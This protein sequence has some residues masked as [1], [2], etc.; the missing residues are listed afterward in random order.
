[1]RQR[2]QKKISEIVADKSASR[3]K[4]VLKQPAQQRFVARERDHAVAYIA[5]RQNPVFAAQPAGAAAVIRD[6][7][8]RGEIGDRPFRSGR[9]IVAWNHVMFQSAQQRRKSRPAAQG[10]DAQAAML[11]VFFRA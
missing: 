1:M 3:V 6:G 4:P 8:D 2:R 9:R 5:W 7:H 11:L 10:D